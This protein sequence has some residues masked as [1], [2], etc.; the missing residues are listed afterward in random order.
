MSRPYT[1]PN[2]P[3]FLLWK[4]PSDSSQE[5]YTVNLGDLW[6]PV[7]SRFNGSCDCKDFVMRRRALFERV[8]FDREQTRCK[9]ILATLDEWERQSIITGFNSLSN[10]NYPI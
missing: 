6:D 1:M 7:E 10:G 5:D 3:N 4:C 9:H 8:G 2:Q